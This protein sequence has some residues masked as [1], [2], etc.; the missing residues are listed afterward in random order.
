MKPIQSKPT[1]QLPARQA[2]DQLAKSQ[3]SIIDY[4]K[5]TP[6]NPAQPTPNILQNLRTG[7]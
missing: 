4:S 3:R 5:L 6:M 2:M 1:Q 7:R